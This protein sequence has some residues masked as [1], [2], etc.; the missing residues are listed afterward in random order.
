MGRETHGLTPPATQRG[1]RSQGIC[2]GRPYWRKK[3]IT[4]S[5]ALC[6][7]K[8]SRAWA[9]RAIE[10]P[11]STKLQT[12]TTCWRLPCGLC[13]GE[14]EPTSLKCIWISSNGF[15]SSLGWGGLLERG[16]RQPVACR[17]FQIGRLERG[18]GTCAACNAF[19]TGQV[20]AQGPRHPLQVLG[21]S[22]APLHN[23]LCDT[24]I[25]TEVG[26]MVRS[27]AR[28]QQR[29]GV[30]IT[31]CQSLAPLLDPTRLH[32]LPLGPIPGEKHEGSSPGD[33]ATGPDLPSILR[34][35]EL[36]SSGKVNSLLFCSIVSSLLHLLDL[37]V[38]L[39][40]SS[41]SS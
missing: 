41:L 1:C 24:D 29:G 19:V 30:G 32:A 22:K 40:L 10:V 23:L 16:T 39:L 28:A 5:N 17:I 31:F 26:P 13:S 8:S 36:S 35:N 4:A 15:R 3:A 37:L 38:S 20:V 9:E 12:S 21:R 33:R 11:A 7:W 6:S 14:T 34:A 18:K 25:P 2:R 27:R